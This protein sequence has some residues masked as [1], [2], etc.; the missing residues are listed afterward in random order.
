MLVGTLGLYNQVNGPAIAN[1]PINAGPPITTVSTPGSVQL[2]EHLTAL[3]AKMY[4]A[5]WCP[6]CH[7]QKQLFGQEAA[8]I[9]DYVECDGEGIDP[10]PALCRSKGIEG[11]PS[12]EINGQIYS[13]AQRLEEL[14]AASGY[15]GSL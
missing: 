10:Q 14:A 1:T 11:Y 2:A 15:T 4:G 7:D 5:Y 6:H 12:W 3:G 9:I 8:K 13:G